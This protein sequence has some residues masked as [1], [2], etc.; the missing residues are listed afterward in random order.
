LIQGKIFISRRLFWFKIK[1]AQLVA[2]IALPAFEWAAPRH[3]ELPYLRY[4]RK[5]VFVLLFEEIGMGKTAVC[6]N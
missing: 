5:K 1:F 3:P 6:R 4:K 2:G